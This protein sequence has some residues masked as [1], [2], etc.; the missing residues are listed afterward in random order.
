MNQNIRIALT[1]LVLIVVWFLSG[2]F[3]QSETLTKQGDI[4]SAA[5][6]SV[7]A[8]WF[9]SELYFR[10]VIARGRT[11]PNRHVTLRAEVAG[12]VTAVPVEKGQLVAEGDA[13]CKLAAEDREQRLVE[14]RAALS[15]AEIEYKG[16][17]KLKQSGYQSKVA[18]A[19]SKARLES[20]RADLKRSELNL[21]NTI[22]LAPFAGFV[23]DRPVEVG[24]FMDRLQVCA[25][26]VEIDPI[27]IT[28]ELSEREVVRLA[29]GNLATARLVTGEEV[30]GK[31]T[32]LSHLA[33]P[34]TRTYQMEITAPNPGKKLRS[35]VTAQI[36]ISA[37]S[38]MAHNIPSSLLALDDAGKLG[39]KVLDEN[40]RVQFSPID[41]LGDDK[42]GVWV[43]GLPERVLVITLGQEYVSR[44]EQVL[45][46]IEELQTAGALSQ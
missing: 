2:L 34:Q 19:Q 38:E 18:I 44:G 46:S 23:D 33:N 41:F 42:S 35:G 6:T 11:E 5:L 10:E 17:L 26:V 3:L 15:R 21:A 28:A 24:D 30:A 7:R 39:V 1:I 4:S 40:K 25:E 12:R 13:V 29:P 32:Y 16:A 37:G 20:A 8:A 31:V 9:Q 36:A 27:K 14:S 45:P 43:A 22:I